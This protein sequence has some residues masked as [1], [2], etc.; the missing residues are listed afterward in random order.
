ML[1]TPSRANFWQFRLIVSTEIASKSAMSRRGSVARQSEWNLR[2]NLD[3]KIWCRG[4]VD[5]AH[6]P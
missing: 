2:D 6:G 3:G 5:F 1:M 4:E